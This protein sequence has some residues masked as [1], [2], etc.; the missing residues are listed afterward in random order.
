MFD[1][2]FTF[3]RQTSRKL[4]LYQEPQHLRKRPTFSLSNF[5]RTIAIPKATTEHH[6]TSWHWFTC[7][8]PESNTLRRVHVIQS[9]TSSKHEGGFYVHFLKQRH[10]RNV[11]KS[12]K[13]NVIKS[14]V[15]VL[16]GDSELNW[17]GKESAYK[18]RPQNQ[19]RHFCEMIDCVIK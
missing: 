10:Y 12:S 6:D 11:W 8:V 2:V 15:L 14:K 19:T 16:F 17:V 9:S 18:S 7:V 5:R 1:K 4:L 3:L 13:V